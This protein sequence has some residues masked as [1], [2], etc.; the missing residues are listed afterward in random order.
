MKYN[1]MNEPARQEL[2]QQLLQHAERL[3]TFLVSSADQGRKYLTL[4]NAGA[5]VALMAFMGNS[6]HL[7]GSTAAWVSLGL[8]ILGTILV[9]LLNACD[10][11]LRQVQFTRWMTGVERLFN[12][13][14]DA[15]A[16]FEPFTFPSLNRLINHLPVIA[17]YAAF[18]CFVAG[19]GLAVTRFLVFSI[20]PMQGD[21]AVFGEGP[22]CALDEISHTMTCRYYSQRHCEASALIAVFVN[23][24]TAFCVPR[25]Q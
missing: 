18:T 22:W 4:V 2:K 24:P 5:A 21:Y 3:R 16:L 25:S 1:E 7:R 17:A 9:G 14:I 23:Y 8:F 13:Q 19:A 15:V 20:H 11:Q 12:N 6:P 10:F